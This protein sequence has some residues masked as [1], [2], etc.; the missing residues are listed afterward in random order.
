MIIFHAR[1]HLIYELEN[2]YCRCGCIEQCNS[3]KK[4]FSWCHLNLYSQINIIINSQNH[5]H[6]NS[7]WLKRS[8]VMRL[9][10]D[11]RGWGAVLVTQVSPVT[12]ASNYLYLWTRWHLA[13]YALIQR[14]LLVFPWVAA[15]NYWRRFDF[16]E[17]TLF[18]MKDSCRERKT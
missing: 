17:W 5:G 14:I 16:A 3:V 1:F 12:S 6:W 11:G 13:K 7:V 18:S 9:K 4:D 10:Y 15:Q 2:Y 8:P